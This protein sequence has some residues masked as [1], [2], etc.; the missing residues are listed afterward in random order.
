MLCIHCGRFSDALLCPVCSAD[1]KGQAYAERYTDR[2]PSCARPIQDRA[3]PCHFCQ[4]GLQAYAPYTGIVLSLLREFKAEEEKKVAKVL[5]PLYIPML[6][7][8]E[9]PLLL[10]IPAS[11]KGFSDRGFDQMT[12]ICSLLEKKAGYPSLRLFDQKGDGQSKFLSRK[13]RQGRQSLTLLSK[14]RK[15]GKLVQQGY[16]FVLLDDITTTGS[17]LATCSSLLSVQYGIDACALVI[18]MV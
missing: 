10:P 15:V 6:S 16:T 9:K 11:R 8:F 5:A 4:K 12:L 1:L 13:E 7:H 18:A 14:D 17:T 2:C 3:Y